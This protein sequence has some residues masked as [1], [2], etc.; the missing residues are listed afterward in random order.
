MPIP[1]RHT[2]TPYTTIQSLFA[3][4]YRCYGGNGDTA[5]SASSVLLLEIGQR[6]HL[7]RRRFVGACSRLAGLCPCRANCSASAPQPSRGQTT[8][9]KAGQLCHTRTTQTQTQT[10]RETHS[11]RQYSRT[12]HAAQCHRATRSS[13]TRWCQPHVRHVGMPCIDDALHARTQWQE[14]M[15][16]YARLAS[17]TYQGHP[18]AAAQQPTEAAQPCGPGP[19]SATASPC[20]ASRPA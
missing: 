2:T 15:H 8:A 11:P 6:A 1:D 10:P 18:G 20:P 4:D 3:V 19:A 5:A 13:E 7:C 9:A 17:A 12:T 16:I 14:Q